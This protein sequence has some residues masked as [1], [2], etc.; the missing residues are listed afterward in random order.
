M[1]KPEKQSVEG[2]KIY[3][4]RS[5]KEIECCIFLAAVEERQ[6]DPLQSEPP[7]CLQTKGQ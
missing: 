1:L 3:S 2:I 6:A 4:E 5:E 7:N